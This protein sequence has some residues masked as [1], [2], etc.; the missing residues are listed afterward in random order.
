MIRATIHAERREALGSVAA[1][2]LRR[3]SRLP[4]VLYGHQ[5]DPVHLSVAR[6]DVEALLHDGARLVDVE[7]GGVVETALLKD[8]QYD[9]MGDHILHMD[10][11]R[12]D[13]DERVTVTVPVELHGLAK[14][15]ASGGNLDHVIQDLEVECPAI[16]IPEVIRLDIREL[17]IG[18]VIH[19]RDVE[20]PER[21]TF[22]QDRDAPVVI[23]HPP[24]A[25][26]AAAEEEAPAEAAG[27]EAADAQQAADRGAGP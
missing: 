2:R 5:R 24:V 16:A 11:A 8:I 1:R 19:V 26:A 25:A 9:A 7:V 20:P 27:P 12:I 18:D 14:G 17:D 13:P 15:V 23:V 22:L 3:Q 10:L 6:R 4:A 21:V